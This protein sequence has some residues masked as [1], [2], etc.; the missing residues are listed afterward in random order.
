MPPKKGEE[1]V[2]KVKPPPWLTPEM[3]E[4]SQNLPALQVGG[5][6]QGW[7]LIATRLIARTTAL[8]IIIQPQVP[9]HFPT[10]NAWVI[11]AQ[12]YM[13]PAYGSKKL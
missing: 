7:I 1:K 12:T 6:Q 3:F 2:K 8:L 5:E 13:M 9:N 4:L 10:S 11:E